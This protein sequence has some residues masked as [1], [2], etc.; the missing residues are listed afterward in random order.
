MEFMTKKLRGVFSV[1]IT[2]MTDDYKVDEKGLRSNIDWQ[3]E[4]GAAGICVV[5]S[6]GEFVALTKEE[7]AFIARV[8]VEHAAG[9]VPVIIGTA[10]ATTYE[11]IEHTKHA[12]QIGADAAMIINPYYCLP[13]PAEVVEF[14]RAVGESVNIPIMAYNNPG[15]SGVDVLPETFAEI[16]KIKNVNYLKDASGEIRRVREIHECTGG[17]I[18]VFNGS[19][20]IALEAFLL[21]AV[22]WICVAGNAIPGECQ[23]VFDLATS[24]KYDEAM[25]VYSKIMPFLEL[26]EKSGKFVHV[27]KAAAGKVGCASGPCRLPRLPLTPEEDRT[28]EA[29][30]RQIGAIK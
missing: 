3:I 17:A 29:V 9:R 13:S 25:R 22:G 15:T 30:L 4:K 14:F 8:S 10:A 7:R 1:L 2:P 18:K 27:A 28:L 19:E 16:A 12:E 26:I 6:T 20:D 21:G 11:V 5:G 24:G 23:K